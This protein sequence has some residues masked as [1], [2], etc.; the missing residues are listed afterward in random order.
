MV[1]LLIIIFTL[2]RLQG[3]VNANGLGYDVVMKLMQPYLNQGYHL[4]VDNVYVQNLIH[5]GS[6][7]HRYYNR[8]R[9]KLPSCSQE[10]KGMGQGEGKGRHALGTRSPML[11]PAMD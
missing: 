1:T 8:D 4:F 6:S 10:Q 9:E 11:S 5:F 3:G 7:C 2:V